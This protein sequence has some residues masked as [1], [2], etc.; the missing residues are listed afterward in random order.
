MTDH[1]LE[2]LAQLWVKQNPPLTN[3]KHMCLQGRSTAAALESPVIVTNRCLCQR[4]DA[5]FNSRFH[6]VRL[7]QTTTTTITGAPP[8]PPL[9][10]FRRNRQPLQLTTCL[11]DMI[12]GDV[13]RD[14]APTPARSCAALESAEGAANVILYHSNVYHVQALTQ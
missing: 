12:R 3:G 13:S 1:F 8:L 5:R 10:R 2:A 9:R 7:Q 6:L 14:P 11:L 4:R